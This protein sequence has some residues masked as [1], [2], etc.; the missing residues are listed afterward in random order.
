VPTS[1]N[2]LA[3]LALAGSLSGRTSWV[4]QPQ[5]LGPALRRFWSANRRLQH[6]WL[7]DLSQ[8]R[9]DALNQDDRFER[10]ALEVWLTEMV[11]RVWGTNW[12]IADRARRGNDVERILANSLHGMARVRRE[13]LLLMVRHWHG[14]TTELISRLDRFRR[15]SERWTDLLIAGPASVYGVWDYAVEPLRARDF[16]RIHESQQPATDNAASLLVSAGLRV[17]FGSSWP[18]HCCGSDDFAELNA[19]VLSTLPAGAFDSSGALL[20]TTS[21]QA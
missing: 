18:L 20:P 13:V 16:G 19:A 3:E 12:T 4:H 11:T 8:I 15:R 2:S 17:M 6:A 5:E 21:W 7:S 14:E 9:E 1:P 10:L